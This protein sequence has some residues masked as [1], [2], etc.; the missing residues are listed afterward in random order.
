MA[1]LHRLGSPDLEK[2]ENDLCTFVGERPIALVLPCH[3]RELGTPALQNI[4]RVLSRV[5]YIDDVVVGLDQADADAWRRASK[6][7]A[8][9]P[10]ARILWN[11]GPRI[12]SL[13]AR[14]SACEL[15][16]GSPGKGRNLWLCAGYVLAGKQARI[17]AAHDCDITTYGPEMLARLCFPVAHPKLGF[18][19]CKGFSA[20]Y[21]DRLN[22]RV[23]RLFLTPLVRSLQS[24]LGANDF[25]DYLDS[26]RYP[27]SG[28]VSMDVEMI[29]RAK[30]P[31]NWGIEVGLLAEVYRI[32]SQKSICQVDI[33]ESYDHKHQE[34]SFADPGKGLNKMAGDIARCLFRTLAGLGVKLD[35]SVF[36][37]LLA[38]YTAKTED[39]MRF[40]S[41]DAEINGLHYDRHEEEAAVAT[42][43]QSLRRAGAEYLSDPLGDPMIP[44]WNRVE[45]MLPDFLPSLLE[46]VALDHEDAATFRDSPELAVPSSS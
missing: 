18:D 45:A 30:I 7:F 20:R 9:I 17:L 38:A 14:L 42:F 44:D 25:L 33:A 40:C 24:I 27:L 32:S 22:G 36:D 8:A 15:N 41:A 39:T 29:R 34:L 23:M 6:I 43:V 2:L 35:R 10:H 46:A 11:D 37:T 16:P 1:T 5:R 4:V 21:T 31:S 12:S 26:F 19:F 13:L 28:E 3:A